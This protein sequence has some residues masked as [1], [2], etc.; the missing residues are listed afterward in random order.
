MRA[1]FEAIIVQ[2]R[3]DQLRHRK[4]GRNAHERFIGKADRAFRN[5][6]HVTGEPEFGKIVDQVVAKPSGTFQPIDFRG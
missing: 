3:L 4:R 6:M 2:T 5:G 1:A